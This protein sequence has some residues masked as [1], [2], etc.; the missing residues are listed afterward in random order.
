MSLDK[1]V[2]R[3]ICHFSERHWGFL[4]L[5][6]LSAQYQQESRYFVLRIEYKYEIPRK[7]M[8]CH[9]EYWWNVVCC[10]CLIPTLFSHSVR[11]FQKI[12][13]H[14]VGEPF[15]SANSNINFK[16]QDT[17]SQYV[18]LLKRAGGPLGPQPSSARPS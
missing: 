16:S 11:T 9:I 10:I 13:P 7:L 4:S 12:I 18:Y 2:T 8:E 3:E 15:I 17:R 1:G 14:C 6:L 5:S